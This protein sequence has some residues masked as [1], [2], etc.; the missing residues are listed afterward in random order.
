MLNGEN[1]EEK[2]LLLDSAVTSFDETF[3]YDGNRDNDGD[4]N[5]E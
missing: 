3:L 4:D 2:M 5:M 1:K